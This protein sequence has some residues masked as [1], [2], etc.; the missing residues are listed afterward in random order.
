M[1]SAP[2]AVRRRGADTTAELAR[3][4]A[5]ILRESAGLDVR[6]VAALRHVRRV[7]DQAGLTHA[8]RAA[9]LAGALSVRRR[10]L[11]RLPAESSGAAGVAFLVDD[12]VTSG[13]TLAEA[14]RALRARGVP[15]TAAATVAAARLRR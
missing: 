9:N 1:P 11:R 6:V 8:E 7:A 2:A 3:A 12:I 15:V 5:R 4:A 13:A 14:S 10:R